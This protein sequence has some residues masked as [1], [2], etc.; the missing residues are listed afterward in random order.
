MN[1][2]LTG[3]SG[4][5]G[6]NLCQMLPSDYHLVTLSRSSAA[7]T[8]DLSTDVPSISTSC[9][10]VIHGAGK[11]HFIPTTEAEAE[12]F[13]N[14]NVKGTENLLRGLQKSDKL[15]QYFVYISSVAVYGAD[16]GHMI[17]ETSPLLAKD[18][19]GKSKIEAEQLIQTWC[20]ENEVIC[21]ILRLPL[22]AGPNPPGN[23]GAMIK[24]IEKGYYFNIAGG[25]AKKSM[26]N[27]VDIATIIPKVALLGGVFN[28]TDRYH[29]NFD[30][31]SA[32]IAKQLNTSKP[33]N[34]P[35]FA[36]KVLAVVGDLLGNKF[37]INSNK[38]EKI[39]ADLTFDD[40]K[41]VKVLG[42]KPK[43]VLEAII[44]K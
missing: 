21:T 10:M 6:R 7:I 19:Y 38:L 8:V 35:F 18:P 13:F 24:G 33:S 32:K 25:K 41:A 36:A 30:E 39:M 42:W 43:L 3:S 1:I 14:V 37:P 28:L 11:A 26:V 40:T 23:L 9:Q 20:A 29:P 34:L 5:L 12:E 44:I 31:L 27:I 22:M 15:P 16:T 17:D 2:L 4:F